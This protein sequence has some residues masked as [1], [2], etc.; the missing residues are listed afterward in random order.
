MLL[1][2]FIET[3]LGLT[4]FAILLIKSLWLETI[5]C[6]ELLLSKEVIR[7]GSKRAPKAPPS[8]PAKK[9]ISIKRIA[10][11]LK[12]RDLF[13]S[14]VNGAFA[15]LSSFEFSIDYLS[16]GHLFL[17]NYNYIVLSCQSEN[18][19]IISKMIPTATII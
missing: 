1:S 14:G 15:F 4:S 7:S 6:P 8:R 3:T 9:A 18:T 12:L 10:P 13:C 17:T 16:Y 2:T 11:V 5:F 19:M